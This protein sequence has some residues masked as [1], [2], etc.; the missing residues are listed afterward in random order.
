MPFY[1][2]GEITGVAVNIHDITEQVAVS[3]NLKRVMRELEHRVKNM[4]ANVRALI[5]RAGRE[6]KTDRGVFEKLQLR[7]EGLSKTHSLLTS[8]QW[9]SAALR[10][11]VAPETIEVYGDERVSI[12]GPNIRVNSEATLALGMVLHELATNA[13]KYGA[14]SVP[15]GHVDVSWSRVNDAESDRL[16]ITWEESGG[17]RPNA[18]D[19][20][21]FGT[22]LIKSTIEG[23]LN[24]KTEVH[25]EPTGLKFVM[26]IMFETA[27]ATL[28]K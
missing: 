11:I 1:T 20:T 21:G 27:T 3:E 12:S 5:N 24:G 8:E 17:P 23:S 6:A 25:W 26:K 14:F 16:V 18:P 13:A 19:R 9:S 15:E 4:L 2:N 7:I 28:Q 10:D 22:Q